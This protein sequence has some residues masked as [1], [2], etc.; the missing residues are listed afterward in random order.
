MVAVVEGATTFTVR[1][2]LAISPTNRLLVP[3]LAEIGQHFD[4]YKVLGLQIIYEPV[5]G[6]ST[7]GLVA[8]SFEPDPDDKAP[9]SRQGLKQ[10]PYTVQT[11]SWEGAVLNIPASAMNRLPVYLTGH[12]DDKPELHVAGRIQWAVDAQADTSEIGDIVI[13]YV[14]ELLDTQATTKSAELL[15]TTAML[16][17]SPL[18]AGNPHAIAAGFT[19]TDMGDG[20]AFNLVP[21]L[22]VSARRIT[23]RNSPVT[24]FTESPAG[25][26]D[27]MYRQLM[28]R[29]AVGS[30]PV[31]QEEGTQVYAPGAYTMTYAFIGTTLAAAAHPIGSDVGAD[32]NVTA[33]SGSFRSALN[34]AATVLVGSFHFTASTEFVFDLTFQDLVATDA[35]ITEMHFVLQ[36]LPLSTTLT[37]S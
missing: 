32:C 12:A 33:A 14:F 24:G 11:Q 15:S 10:R 35:G 27:N 17:R 6:T 9:N 13:R 16:I 5:V 3:W 2:D 37:T 29:E 23:F 18:T 19:A 36:K 1:G 31:I 20:S 4:R 7:K 22:N 21:F 8:L 30:T 28:H 26:G 25:E 34:A